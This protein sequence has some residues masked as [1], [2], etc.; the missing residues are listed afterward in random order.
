MAVPLTLALVGSNVSSGN[1][2]LSL[3]RRC[4]CS[5]SENSTLLSDELSFPPSPDLYLDSFLSSL[6]EVPSFL[7]DFDIPE[8]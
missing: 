1:P 6:D 7:R 8:S 2:R 5:S 3:K 4:D